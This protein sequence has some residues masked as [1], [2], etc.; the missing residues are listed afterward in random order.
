MNKIPNNPYIVGNP[1]KT[2]EMFFGRED[3][4]MFVTRKVG[5]EKANQV[6]IFCGERRSGKTSILFQILSG[7]LG[8]FFLP[9]LVDM[10]ILAGLKS[11]LEFFRAV[12]EVGCESL[13]IPGL[14]LE[15]VEK[16]AREKTVERIFEAFLAFVAKS[17]PGKVVLFLLDEYEL[18]EAK[19]K[20]GSLSESVIHYLSGVLESKYR[21]S[22]IF[23]GSTNLENRKVDYWKSLLGKSIYRKI[24][25]L[26]EHDTRRLITEPLKNHIDYPD[27]VIDRIYRLTG[28]QPFYTQVMCQNLVDILM[29]EGRNDPEKKDLESVVKDIIENPLPQMIYSWNS[30]GDWI[31]FTMSSLAGACHTSK[32][33][34]DAQSVYQ[35]L[36]KSKIALTFKRE[37]LNV[38]LEEAYQ[39]EFLQKNDQSEYCFKMDLYRRWIRKEHSIWKVIKEVKLEIKKSAGIKKIVAIAAAAGILVGIGIVITFIIINGGSQHAVT[40]EDGQI[41]GLKVISNQAPFQVMIDDALTVTSQG[42]ENEKELVLPPL[43]PGKHV[44]V[45]QNPRTKERRVDTVEIK[46]GMNDLSIRFLQEDPGS[47]MSADAGSLFVSSSPDGAKIYIDGKYHA[48]SPKV[49]SNI[50]AGR[51]KVTV[52]REGYRTEEFWVDVTVQGIT[53]RKIQLSPVYGYVSFKILPTAKIYLDGAFL[54]EVPI[55]EPSRIQ[56][57]KHTLTI[58]N[59]SMGYREDIPIVVKEG[60]TVPIERKLR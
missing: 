41:R 55:V 2:K 47:N 48:T 43:L 58:V 56:T 27:E 52:E 26:S 38:F 34:A 36:S 32:D 8:E 9:I 33:W 50:T 5:V 3:D 25:Y 13:K 42:L 37:R 19:I 23:T 1:I 12:L 14:T 30:L 16:E 21:I 18:I 46:A 17:C 35:Y 29:E 40:V 15:A 10:Q 39:K 45:Y 44:F 28:G 31:K 24:S 6:I 60:E 57:G 22:F 53:E 49:I 4:F 59:E 54:V 20:E 7:Q 51:H 11:D